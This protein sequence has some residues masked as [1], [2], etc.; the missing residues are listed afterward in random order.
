MKIIHLSTSDLNG[1]AAIA[2][3]RVYKAQLKNSNLDPHFLV[4]QKKSND[5]SVTAFAPS[6]FKRF[7]STLNIWADELTIRMFSEK[8]GQLLFLFEKG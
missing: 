5:D 2:A 6:S 7:I 4:Q 3:Y 8:S 1:G